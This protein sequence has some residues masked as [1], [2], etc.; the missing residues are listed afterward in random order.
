[1]AKN[2]RSALLLAGALVLSFSATARAERSPLI[3]TPGGV[4]VVPPNVANIPPYPS[5]GSVGGVPL[6]PLPPTYALPLPSA[7]QGSALPPRVAVKREPEAT[8]YSPYAHLS[9]LPKDPE[10]DVP[11]VL[12]APEATAPGAPTKVV[13]PPSDAEQ[14]AAGKLKLARKLLEEQQADAARES[15]RDLVK[16]YP[17]TRAAEEAKRLLE[18]TR[19]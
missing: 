6:Y 3:L 15:L 8:P 17:E 2:R 11:P 12:P 5:T 10:P 19:P 9:F 4:A 13:I 16:R 7:R 18:P 1:M 14:K